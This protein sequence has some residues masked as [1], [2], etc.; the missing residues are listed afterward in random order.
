MYKL[1]IK[2]AFVNRHVFESPWICVCIMIGFK[3]TWIHCSLQ[4]IKFELINNVD[5]KIA[6]GIRM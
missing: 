5:K 1:I 6:R 4:P 2:G 3:F